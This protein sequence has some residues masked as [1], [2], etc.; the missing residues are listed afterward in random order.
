MKNSH[1]RR[2]RL[3]A[4]VCAFTLLASAM[5]SAFGSQMRV[6]LTFDDSLKDHLL[7]A[8]PLLEKHG[9]RGTFNIVTDWVG[10]GEKFLTWEDVGELV[11]RGHEIATHTKTHRSLVK[12]LAEEGEEAV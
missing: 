2:V 4:L 5:P 7:I 9:W 3:G 8:A 6:A 1:R 10:S 11:R 12:L